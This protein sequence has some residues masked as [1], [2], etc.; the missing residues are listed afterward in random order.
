[1]YT[2]IALNTILTPIRIA[3]YP[4][5]YYKQLSS[6]NNPLYR[7]GIS[8]TVMPV[9]LPLKGDLRRTFSNTP[10]AISGYGRDESKLDSGRDQLPCD[11]KISFVNIIKGKD[12][13]CKKASRICDLYKIKLTKN[14]IYVLF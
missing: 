8:K 13:K 7:E 12:E 2:Q 3:I 10:S 9:C 5:F 11:M 4:A 1:M 14:K 6:S